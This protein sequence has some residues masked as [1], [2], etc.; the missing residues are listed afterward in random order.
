MT[1]DP[2][3]VIMSIVCFYRGAERLCKAISVYRP[4]R[5]FVRGDPYFVPT[6][7][8]PPASDRP[9]LGKRTVYSNAQKD[10]SIFVPLCE[11]INTKI[12]FKIEPR[13]MRP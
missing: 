2:Y 9:N 13:S 1:E 3:I 11:W 4:G 8:S 10:S 12:Q 5:Q 6:S 7:C